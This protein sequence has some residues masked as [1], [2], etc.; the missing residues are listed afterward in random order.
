[1]RTEQTVQECI[2]RRCV[3]GRRWSQSPV[4]DGKVATQ[5]QLGCRGRDLP[6]AVGLNNAAG[7]QSVRFLSDRLMQHVVELAQLVAPEAETCGVFSLDPKSRASE[8]SG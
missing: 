3:L 7:D 8:V 4:V 1:M 2:A 6:L 5:P